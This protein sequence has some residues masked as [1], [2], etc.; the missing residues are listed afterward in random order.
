MA[1]AASRERLIVVAH[2]GEL[3]A[4]AAAAYAERIA[5]ADAGAHAGHLRRSW[6]ISAD[7]LLACGCALPTEQAS[8]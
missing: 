5:L 4:A 2:H 3:Q 1:L 6:V 7:L 8:G